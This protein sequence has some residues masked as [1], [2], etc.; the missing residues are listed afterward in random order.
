MRQENER[1]HVSAAHQKAPNKETAMRKEN[2]FTLV[3]LL[4]VIGIIS[5]LIAMLLPALNKAREA[6]YT[7]QCASN[8]RQ[9]AVAAR[10]YCND[11][12]GYT[13]SQAWQNPSW[14]MQ[15]YQGNPTHMPGI[16]DY[17][18]HPYP[19]TPAEYIKDTVMTCVA[20]QHSR[21]THG[22]P[23]NRTY[24]MNKYMTF[25]SYIN[26]PADP[27]PAMRGVEKITQVTHPS[28]ACWFFCGDVSDYDSAG[29]YYYQTAFTPQ[30]K[31]ID[32]GRKPTKGP[33]VL[34][35]PHNDG[36]NVAFVDG[37]VS[38]LSRQEFGIDH[39]ALYVKNNWFWM[40]RNVY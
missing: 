31:L 4:V 18:F 36:L 2:G 20:C 8:L 11:N 35:Y 40:G 14:Q 7:V 15:T 17:L 1:G 30:Q 39:P 3:E 10:M 38:R 23:F 21:E 13:F 12:K 5:I 28:E 9:I 37:H 29:G 19:T 32:D 33:D 27:N 16:A 22:W 6:A 24:T 26:T 34:F 25:M